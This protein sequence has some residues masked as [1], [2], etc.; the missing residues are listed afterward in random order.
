[1]TIRRLTIEKS[2]KYPFC[3]DSCAES[4]QDFRW[5][6]LGDGWY[7]VVLDG[8]LIHMR[9]NDDGVEYESDSD[10]DL[11]CL[12]R[13]YFRLDDDLDAI[14]DCI[15]SQCDTVARL[16]KKYRSHR[17]LR[18][19]DP[20]ECM[21]AF[22]CSTRNPPPGIFGM[23]ERIAEKIGNRV[24]L[25]GEVR[26]TF[27]TPKRILE[28]DDAGELENLDLGLSRVPNIIAAAKQIC[29]GTL[30]LGKLAHPDVPYDAAK[31]QLKACEGVGPKVADCVA[32][33]SLGKMEAFPVDSRVY[34]AVEAYYSVPGL[35]KKSPVSINRAI[36]IWAQERFGPYAGYANQLL[37]MD[38]G[39][40][41]RNRED[42]PR[43]CGGPHLL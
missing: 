34:T 17:I 3:L 15:S 25:N 18:Q 37:Y 36:V 14:Y 40:Y 42:Y 41:P 9:Q 26:Y 32:L 10:A 12:L 43:R 11:D 2:N 5:C 16:V 22:L 27:P 13:S 30:D 35:E 29:N 4:A 28:A 1:M 8:N 38:N 33:F 23:V 6:K 20:W 7:S 21:A 31:S 19:P 24:C 39:G